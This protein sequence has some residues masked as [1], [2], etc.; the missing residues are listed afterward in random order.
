MGVRFLIAIE[1]M[2]ATTVALVLAH[3]AVEIA[4]AT[5]R[6]FRWSNYWNRTSGNIA[7]EIC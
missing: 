7:A 1:W 6:R 5:W 4:G 3:L 2:L